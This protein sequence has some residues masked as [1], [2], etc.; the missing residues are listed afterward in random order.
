MF[1]K[2]LCI[3]LALTV[4]LVSFSGCG[5]QV[6]TAKVDKSASIADFAAYKKEITAIMDGS[7]VK[8]TYSEQVFGNEAT[9]KA[10]TPYI[11]IMKFD[12]QTALKEE[13]IVGLTN[14]N[15]MESFTVSIQLDRKTIKDCKLNIRDYPYLRKIFNLVSVIQVSAFGCNSLLSSTRSGIEKAYAA[16]PKSFYKSKNKY[17]GQD[18]TKTW[19]LQYTI[20]YQTAAIPTVFEETLAFQGN[21]APRAAVK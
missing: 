21:L 3:L 20:Y 16:H 17:F 15:S 12:L 18:K 1:K 19:F 6:V 14:K 9:A 5:K 2:V 11:L 10:A 8:Y 13:I 7:G 4:M